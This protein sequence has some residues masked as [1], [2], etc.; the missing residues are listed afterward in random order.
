MSDQYNTLIGQLAQQ[1][2]RF[3]ALS[4]LDRPE[5]QI[6]FPGQFQEHDVIWDAQLL[7]LQSVY[8][9]QLTQGQVKPDTPVTLRQYIHIHPAAGDRIPITIA[10][11]VTQFDEPTILKTMIM[12]HNYK[13]LRPG[14]HEYGEPVIFPESDNQKG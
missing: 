7:T 8:Q 9:L 13:R 10:L 4:P 5:V 2:R 12:I 14:R 6:Q 1:R 3:L 11:N